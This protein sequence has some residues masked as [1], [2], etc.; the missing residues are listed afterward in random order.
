M[1]LEN[2]QSIIERALSNTEYQEFLFTD[3]DEA[4]RGYELTEAEKSTL[5]NLGSGTYT[6]ARRG[7]IEA[8]KLVQAAQ[9]YQILE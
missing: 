9:E 5:R 1:S 3:P 8:K 4:L 2:V 6:R 7:L